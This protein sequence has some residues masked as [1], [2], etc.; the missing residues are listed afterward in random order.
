MEVRMV[1]IAVVEDNQITA[2][3]IKKTILEVLCSL[4]VKKGEYQLDHYYEGESAL[5]SEFEYDI[6]FLD[7]DL[8][9]GINGFEVA[10]IMRA[11]YRVKPLFIVLTNFTDRGEES[12]D[13]RAYWYLTKS[14]LEE[15]LHNIVKEVIPTE[16]VFIK[17]RGEEIF[18]YFNHIRFIQRLESGIFIYTIDSVFLTYKGRVLNQWQ[19][20]LPKD[21]FVTAHKSNIVNLDY[22]NEIYKDRISMNYPQKNE[23]VRIASHRV[24]KI[25]NTY[26]DYLLAKAKRRV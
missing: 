24:K 23:E 14:S 26:K 17:V 21:Q 22:I 19:E 18:V 15:K 6:S 10:R 4:G 16:G 20:I 5:D 1:K 7:I 11:T 25:E 3:K 12:S 8:G 13:I 2:D 9:V